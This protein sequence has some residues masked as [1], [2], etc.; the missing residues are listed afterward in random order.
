VCEGE[1]NQAGKGNNSNTREG[2]THRRWLSSKSLSSHVQ[3]QQWEGFEAKMVSTELSKTDHGLKYLKK[4]GD[5]PRS[6]SLNPCVRD[7]L[8]LSRAPV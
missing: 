1:K 7:A 5:F 3:S 4:I 6:G 8:A 2:R